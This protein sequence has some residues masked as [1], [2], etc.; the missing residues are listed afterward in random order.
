MKKQFFLFAYALIAFSTT[1]FAQV[2]TQPAIIQQGYDG[3]V[4]II[5][6]PNEGNKGMVGATAC[7]AHT[8][9]TYNGKQWQNAPTWRSA[10]EKHKMTQNADGNWELK[11]T[12]SIN[13][14]YGISDTI[15]VTQ[16]SFVFNDGKGGTKEGKA[17]GDKDIFVDLVEAGFT[18]A[19][20]AAVPAIS[21]KGTQVTVTAMATE[22]CHLRLLQNGTE[23][24]T[25]EG[26]ELSYTTTLTAEGDYVFECIGET[27]TKMASETLSTCVPAAPQRA[28]RPAGVLNGIYYDSLDD[29]KVTLCTYAASK[30]EAAKHVFVVG[31]FNDWTISDQYQLK[32]A[33]DSAYFW[34]TLDGLTPKEEYAFQYVVV[35]ADGVVKRISDLYSEKVLHPDDQYEPVT[36]DNT[37]KAYPKQADGYCTVIQTGREP[38]AWSDATLN[39]KRPN[40]NN[41]IIY[42]LWVYDYTPSRSI[43]ALMK[44]LDYLETLGVNAIELMPVC[45]FDGN[46]NWGYSPNHYFALDKA[47][48]SPDMLKAFVDE[49][50]KRGMAV[51]LDMV[52]NHATGLNPMN[53]LYPYGTDLKENPWFN[54]KAPHSDNVY[55]D[56]NHGFAPA[57]AMFTR[58]L[59]YWLRE[60]KVDG[61]RMDLSH[62]FCDT[63]ANTSVKH[64]K[65]YYE[66]GVKTVA[67]DAYFILEHWG[68]NMGSERPQLINAGMLC[69]QN[70][71]NAYCQTAMGWLKEG[72]SFDDANKDGYISYC[73]SHDEERM[74]YKCKAY[75]N[76]AIK[77]DE[78]VRLGRI[79][80][81]IVFNVLLNGPHM[82]WQYEEIGFDFSINSSLDKPDGTSND[83]RCSKKPR[84]E[85][86]G[87]FKDSRRMAQY[88]KVAQ[89]CQLRTRLMPEVFAGNP[90]AVSVGSGNSI[91]TIQWGNDVFVVA[92]FHPTSAQDAVL[93]AGTWYDYYNGG[94][95]VAGGTTL[96]LHAGEVRIF[97]GKTVKLPEVP[98]SFDFAASI[99]ETEMRFEL[100]IVGC[101]KILLNGEILIRRGEQLYDLTG[102]RRL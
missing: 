51:I 16:L 89:A 81:N 76:G 97:T 42:E 79:A 32:Q 65:D 98:Q 91:R 1:L 99:G 96:S 69:W 53:K 15:T 101:E 78:S 94:T 3:E 36:V 84:P 7:Y 41:L 49:C 18:V 60:Y 5:F 92:N 21:E 24:K 30:T 33:N 64:I 35:R 67:E 88:A 87:Y 80:E 90:T 31:D 10:L 52:F 77:T 12:P 93:P 100:E 70:T 9:I 63:V 48:G 19:F 8:G 37:L 54:V 74:Q 23:V 27:G 46:Y 26:K 11:I 38:Y 66:N 59:Q 17:E 29:T 73:E 57:H 13:A 72:D 40:K 68:A 43:P 14:Y 55:E 6:N 20:T 25:A 86:R 45:E 22:E 82:I 47:Y 39:F 75:G 34:I 28:N 61:Y 56:W 62:G 50:H 58:A 4:T 95:S 102:R 2:T 71:S 85:N 83:D 44:R